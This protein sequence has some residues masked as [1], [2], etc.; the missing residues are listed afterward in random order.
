M[1]LSK[2]DQIRELGNLIT[3]NFDWDCFVGFNSD[4]KTDSGF[5]SRSDNMIV[6]SFRE[7]AFAKFCNLDLKRIDKNGKDYELLVPSDLLHILP[8]KNHLYRFTLE[9]K[10]QEKVHRKRAP[11]S[12]VYKERNI[13]QKDDTYPI[14]I[15]N[16]M[17]SDDNKK[18]DIKTF[19][20]KCKE[21]KT[22]D[23]Y[24]INQTNVKDF[25]IAILDEE[26]VRSRMYAYGDG[27]YADF[28]R[29]HIHFLD[30]PVITPIQLNDYF[31][32]EEN[33]TKINLNLT[34]S[35]ILEQSLNA[36]FDLYSKVHKERKTIMNYFN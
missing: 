1:S 20:E 32:S 13:I 18:T 5:S 22:C 7:K 34:M 4:L 25:R 27:A 16:M 3:N 15:K 36:R 28:E 10:S 12:D 24:I 6:S 31:F 26:Y 14:K 33:S 29:E 8:S 35:E 11:S 30:L 21:T 23:F 9:Y 19:V 2:L 17:G